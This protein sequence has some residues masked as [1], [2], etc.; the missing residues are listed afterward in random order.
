LLFSNA[1]VSQILT[2]LTFPFTSSTH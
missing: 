2:P 1:A